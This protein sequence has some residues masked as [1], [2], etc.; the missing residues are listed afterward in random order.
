[1][2]LS[3]TLSVTL[4]SR[5]IGTALIG[6]LAGPAAN[7]GA[8]ALPMSA[9]QLGRISAPAGQVDAGPLAASAGQLAG[10]IPEALAAL[11]LG[12]AVMRPLTALI[13]LA[14]Q[15]AA[16][17]L[18]AQ[19]N[20]VLTRLK[21]ELDNPPAGGQVA[22]LLRL[23]ELL[24]DAPEGQ[25]LARLLQAV[26][27]TGA[28]APGLAFPFLDVLRGA[29]G[30]VQVLGGLMSLETVL[31]EAERLAGLLT[32][33]LDAA[34]IADADR[35]LR[36]LLGEGATSLAVRLA[37]L[38]P[39]DTP[40]LAGAMAQ[41]AAVVAALARLRGLYA[42]GFGPGEATLAYLDI[43]RLQAQL[44]A[45]RT[46][47][48]E[49]D[50]DPA[51]RATEALAALLQPLLN[52]NLGNG[53]AGQLDQLL[54]G[55]AAQVATLAASIASLDLEALTAPLTTGLATLMQPLR[56]IQHLV[57]EV[58]QGL[59]G[60]LDGVRAAVAALPLD[61]VAAALQAFMAPIAQALDAVRAVLAEVMAALQ[62]AADAST[63]ALTQVD[64]ALA[65]FQQ[66]LDA[67]FAQAHQ[68]LAEADL[69]AVVGSV[70]QKV[71]AFADTLAQAQM[72][73]YF[74]T[75]VSAIGAATDVV[76]AVPFGLLPESMK[77]EVDAAV[78]P[79]KAVDADAVSTQIKTTLGIGPD[80]F[81]L[82]DDLEAAIAEVQAKFD[83]LL[84]LVE[85]NDPQ[86][87]LAPVDARLHSL[88]EQV[89]GL[90]PDLTLAP[91]REALDSVKAT[92][93]SLDPDALLQPVRDAFGQV[94]AALD[95]LS[96]ASLVAPVQ[97]RITSVRTAL[98]AA[99]HLDDW[100]AGLD[101]LRTQTLA[102]LDKADPQQLQAPLHGALVEL[103][104]ALARF[105]AAQ[106]GTALGTVVA[107]LLAATGQRVQ[108]QSFVA[109]SAW[110]AA[111]PGTPSGSVA[112]AA[113]SSAFAGSL[114]QARLLV[115]QLSPATLATALNPRLA[116]LAAATQA[117]ATR[118]GAGHPGTA[119]L[120]KLRG[121]LD[122][123]AVLGEL[124]TLHGRYLAALRQAEGRAAQFRAGGFSEADVGCAAL[125]R[126]LEP[127]SP[128]FSQVRAL[129]RA[130]GIPADEL[131]VA[132][133]ARRLLAAAPPERLV[134]LVMPVF[135]ALHRRL[136]QLLDG[137]ITPLRS[138][139]TEL[140]ALLDA[141]DLAPLVAAADGIV[142]Q[143]RSEIDA[144]HPDHVLAEPLAAFTALR[145]ALL[146]TDPLAAVTTILDNLRTLVAQV[147]DKLDLQKLLAE[148]LAIYREIL[149]VL[150]GID[151]AALLAPVFDQLDA[152]A[153]QVDSGLDDTVTGFK[154]LQDA[155]PAGGGGSSLS[156][157]V[158]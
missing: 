92:L 20:S 119:T 116:E 151:P 60:A 35:A 136:A 8:L 7:L 49:A 98:L 19:F 76:Q 56:D 68:A 42:D 152:I 91:L 82:R 63:A 111:A 45:A 50:A 1:M 141:V 110:L 9:E 13:D 131:S 96:V 23:A 43:D 155:L 149:G 79:V 53:P 25:A 135:E 106:G 28:L 16:N 78:Q 150:H 139:S 58:L 93:R 144:L 47:I 105:P 34:A 137:V 107:G 44:D 29:N 117:L 57:D 134:G 103:G 102:L 12:D 104:D 126:V 64:A 85:A 154:R 146:A 2:G 80:G 73:P 51:R 61:D 5:A 39:S 38:D 48:R 36:G 52:F 120:L 18:P 17:D 99:I 40:V 147:L 14:G 65:A 88:A 95:G 32:A 142:A 143:V 158:A 123:A 101:A 127:L 87:L 15:V 124:A 81:A 62:T 31:A 37:T 41:L 128:A 121:G 140:R 72:K 4:D 138:G 54:D 153:E 148:P 89:R 77:A 74:D 24:R 130:I 55:V 114:A 3:A 157:S 118:L 83:A 6:Q 132:G 26:L 129:F 70:A 90:A 145:Q 67:L 115:E 75:A 69:D 10:R 21:A 113:R 108:P 122:G 59:R 84:A 133:V 112:L 71:Q 97:Q 22:L 100:D 66:Q 11:P 125:R 86:T 156:V 33:R 46:A 30:A 27:P 94:T 109:V